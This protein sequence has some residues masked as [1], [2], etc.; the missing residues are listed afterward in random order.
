[1]NFLLRFQEVSVEIVT[2]VNTG[3]KTS[4]AIKAEANDCYVDGHSALSAPN[5]YVEG[6]TGTRTAVK[7]ESNDRSIFHVIRDSAERRH[8]TNG[9]TQTMTFVEAEQTDS[10][11]PNSALGAIPRCSLR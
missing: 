7:R 4:T 10:D 3:T 6:A 11:A 9:G 8:P 1:M 5:G 2:D